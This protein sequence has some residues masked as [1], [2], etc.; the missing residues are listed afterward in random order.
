VI[1]LPS[2]LREATGRS[3][4]GYQIAPASSEAP[5]AHIA[6]LDLQAINVTWLVDGNAAGAEIKSRLRQHGIPERR[7]VTLGGAGS[8]IVFEDLISIDVYVAAINREL[9]RS[10]VPARL[11]KAELA[12]K[13]R[14]AALAGWCK[15]NKVVCP[16][17][18]DV[19]NRVLDQKR[20][21]PL[22]AWTRRNILITLDRR[23]NSSFG[24]TPSGD[25]AREIGS[26]LK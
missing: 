7:M 4:L 21:R 22:L 15:T 2:L 25:L 8:G 19:A 6:G 10:G 14:P 13:N 17:R 16:T 24:I 11:N 23:L 26:F 5:A 18:V 12:H 9:E 3:S 1:L 20:D